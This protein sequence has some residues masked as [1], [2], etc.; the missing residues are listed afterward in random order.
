MHPLQYHAVPKWYHSLLELRGFGVLGIAYKLRVRPRS[1]RCWAIGC[2]SMCEARCVGKNRHENGVFG[3]GHHK[4][5]LVESQPLAQLRNLMVTR[6]CLLAWICSMLDIPWVLEQ[7]G[8][9]LLQWHP[10]FQ[11]LAKKFDIWRAAWLLWYQVGWDSK[12]SI[13][14]KY[15]N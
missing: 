2:D 4:L 8:S 1:T 6:C 15:H 13:Y 5:D 7:P 14:I 11:K 10:A 3:S 12:S 9:S